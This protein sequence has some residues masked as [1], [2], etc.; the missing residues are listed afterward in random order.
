MEDKLDKK[1]IEINLVIEKQSK[2]QDE[3]NQKLKEFEEIKNYQKEISK[4]LENYKLNNIDIEK[5]KNDFKLDLENMKKE[6][7]N[8]YNLNKEEVKNE[9]KGIKAI[10]KNQ[11]KELH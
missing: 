10:V 3:F 9:I 7:N 2:L 11:K 6:M 1:V 5:S 4:Y 8:T